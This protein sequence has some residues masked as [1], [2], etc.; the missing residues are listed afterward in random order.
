M[1]Q[2]SIDRE[3]VRDFQRKLYLKA[4]QEKKFRFYVL[5]DKISDERFLREAYRRVKANKGAPGVDGKSFEDVEAG[6]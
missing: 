3:K 4:K 2:K 1:N 5:Y 6:A